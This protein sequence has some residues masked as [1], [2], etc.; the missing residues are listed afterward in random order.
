MNYLICPETNNEYFN[1]LEKS[2]EKY[3]IKINIEEIKDANTIFYIDID[4]QIPFDKLKSLNCKKYLY[5]HNIYITDELNLFDKI[6]CPYQNDNYIW[7][8]F[9]I[10]SIDNNCNLIE[11]KINLF[12]DF[13]NINLIKNIFNNSDKLINDFVYKKEDKYK[14]TI[15]NG[16][17]LTFDHIKIIRDG[18]LLIAE[19]N[20]E[21]LDYG[22]INKF[23]CILFNENNFFDCLDY[24]YKNDITKLIDNGK[25][26]LLSKTLNNECY[27]LFNTTNNVIDYLSSNPLKVSNCFVLLQFC[28]NNNYKLNIYSNQNN[29]EIVDYLTLINNNNIKLAFY[30]LNE[31]KEYNN[32][33]IIIRDNKNGNY[34][35]SLLSEFHESNKNNDLIVNNKIGNNFLKIMGINANVINPVCNFINIKKKKSIVG[36]FGKIDNENEQ[37]IDYLLNNGYSIYN[38]LQ[39]KKEINNKYDGNKK[40]R[41][42]LRYSL[43]DIHNILS[44]EVKYL[45]YNNNELT[46]LFSINYCIPLITFDYLGDT[47]EIPYLLYKDIESNIFDNIIN[48][49]DS[50]I[51]LNNKL[52]M[53][54]I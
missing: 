5:T 47:I 53:K 36:I 9:R 41:F 43:S 40:V 52:I 15:I 44:N 34:K 17:N 29:K 22:F 13:T 3:F 24:I 14:F 27:N 39:N 4:N 31:Y 11:N 45:I 28:K 32:K 35:L 37:L 25:F 26:L 33:N 8:P 42:I 12:N 6:F 18:S 38:I 54:I 7:F 21:L 51:K 23:N 49:R 1:I 20:K 30:S 19:E 16:K 50:N 2:L 10:N 48:Y 46:S